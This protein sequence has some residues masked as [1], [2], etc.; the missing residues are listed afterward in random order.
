MELIMYLNT[1]NKIKMNTSNILY[2]VKLSY[3]IH[4]KTSAVQK[5]QIWADNR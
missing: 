2:L 4:H 3:I 1:G 5:Y